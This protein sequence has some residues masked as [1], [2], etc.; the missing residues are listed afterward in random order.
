MSFETISV[1]GLGYIGL[2]TAAVFASRKKKVVG[3]DVNQKAVDIINRGEIHI[4][5][6]DLDMVVHAAVTE[7]YLRAT[8]QP[9]AADAFLIAVPTPFKD[10]HEPDL[11][12]IESA[13]KAIAPVLKKGDLVILESTSPVGATEQ[14]AVWLAEARPDLSF[15]QARGEMSDIRV[16]HCPER[17]LPGHVLRE[18]VQNDRV[19]GGMTPK[20]SEAAVRLYKTFVEGECIITSARTAEM[21]KLT[22]NSFRDV[23]IAFANELSIICDKLDINVWELIRL[24]NRHP[25]VNILQPGPG[26]GGHCIAVD[27]WFIV[28][29]TPEQARLIRTAREVND[30]KREWV[31]N[32]VKLA[33]ADFLQANPEKTTKNV[34]IACF[35]LAFKPDIDDLRESPA[36]EITKKIAG[37]HSGPVLAIE[38]N[39]SDLPSDCLNLT[40]VDLEVGIRSSD[41]K[42][43]LVKHKEFH[44]LDEPHGVYVDTQGLWSGL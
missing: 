37:F 4:V 28:S 3:V 44:L 9:E 2:P 18:L 23:N 22:E 40:L 17:V 15:P 11:S 38:P 41:L 19:I 26:V 12:Y 1:I 35:G 32:K 25:R 39:I 42:V 30:G 36:F 13:S 31:I 8:S 21:C 10:D 34:T 16:A 20:C 14:M 27:P 7:G 6:P 5:E 24:A 33:V 43:I 29:K